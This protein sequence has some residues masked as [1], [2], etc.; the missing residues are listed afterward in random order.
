M[1]KQSQ[2]KETTQTPSIPKLAYSVR[3]SSAATGLCEESIRRLIK[4]G[5]LK[6]CSS[7]RHKLIPV[8]ELEKFLRN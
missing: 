6:C 8:A 7:V 5:K 3:E 4:R 2:L 1:S